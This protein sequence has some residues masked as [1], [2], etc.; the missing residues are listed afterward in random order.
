[1][2]SLKLCIKKKLSTKRIISDII[3][4]EYISRK[5][6]ELIYSS[7]EKLLKYFLYTVISYI[8]VNIPLSDF[9]IKCLYTWIFL[10]NIK[11]TKKLIKNYIK[12]YQDKQ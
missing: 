5:Y 1:M 9:I 10:W 6:Y 11:N 4:F 3:N 2:H 7:L 12:F 8:L